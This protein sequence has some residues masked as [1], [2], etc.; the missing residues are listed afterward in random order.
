MQRSPCPLGNHQSQHTPRNDTHFHFFEDGQF[1]RSFSKR[2]LQTKQHPIF[3]CFLLFAIACGR[4]YSL[5]LACISSHSCPCSC[6]LALACPPDSPPTLPASLPAR[7]PSAACYLLVFA[8]LCCF[9][10]TCSHGGVVF[11]AA[12]YRR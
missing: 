4:F 10:L 8:Y 3:W 7:L 2:P 5:C 12:C 11:L 6:L 1:G 9:A